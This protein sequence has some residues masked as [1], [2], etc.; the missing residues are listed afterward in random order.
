MSEYGF[1]EIADQ[2]CKAPPGIGLTSGGG[3]AEG[4]TKTR[5]VCYACG[6]HVCSACSSVIQYRDRGYR[7]ICDR[8]QVEMGRDREV[9]VRQYRR[10]GYTDPAFLRRVL[11]GEVD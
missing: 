5:L 11:K 4:T 3:Y 8:C 10:A 9:R 6:L 7:R 2:H 1:C